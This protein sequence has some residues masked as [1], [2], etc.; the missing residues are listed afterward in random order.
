M[1]LHPLLERIMRI[2][3]TEEARHLSFARHYLKKHVPQLGWLRHIGL[4]IGAPLVLSSMAQMMLKPSRR[5]VRHYQIPKTVIKEAFTDSQDHKDGT[6]ASLRKVRRLCEEL[7]ILGPAAQRL[8][9][10][11]GLYERQ[12]VTDGQS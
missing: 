12:V 7:G 5:I 4:A 9:R 1:P 10:V 11:L 8:W 2:H 6:L 3:V